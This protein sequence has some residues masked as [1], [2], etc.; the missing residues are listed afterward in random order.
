MTLF[1]VGVVI[2][3]LMIVVALLLPGLLNSRRNASRINCINNLKQAGIACRIWE[4]D[5]GDKY[6][7]GISVTSGGAMELAA[8]GNVFASF[9]VMSN[10]LSTPRILVCPE[11]TNRIAAYSF[12]GFVAN[13]NVSYFVGVDVTNDMNPQLFLSGDGNFAIGGTPVNPGLL[14]LWTN[15]PVTWTGARHVDHGNIGFAD[16]AV[17]QTDDKL[18][19][20]K[21]RETG[22]ATNRL[23]I[24]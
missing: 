21:L 18:L 15:A 12:A 17:W 24:P 4:G 11:D 6:P 22:F 7:M 3:A 20:E 19:V 23:A 9:L 16:G 5:N 1:E 14:P 8:T 13:S 2:G 10:E